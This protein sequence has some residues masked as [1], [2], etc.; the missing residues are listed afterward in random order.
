VDAQLIRSLEEL[1]QLVNFHSLQQPDGSVT[2]YVGGQTAL[3]TN[4]QAYAIQGDF[5]TSQTRI[6][7]GTGADISGQLTVRSL[8]PCWKI[9]ILLFP[10]TSVT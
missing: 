9:R 4:D 2:V 3:V 8:E 6:L 1:S 10:H 5:S 7:S